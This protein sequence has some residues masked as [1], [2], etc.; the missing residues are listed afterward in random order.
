[1]KRTMKKTLALT[2]CLIMVVSCFTGIITNVQATGVSPIAGDINGDGN[3]NN[4]DLTRLL[5]YIAGEDVEVVTVTIDPNG[6]GN[7]NNKDL[8]RL[9][10]YIAGEAV[11]IF[12]TGCAHEKE[13]V[14]ATKATCTKEGNIAYWYCADCDEYFSDAEGVVKITLEDTVIE[15]I[16]HTEET[17]PG[18]PAT[19]TKTGLTDGVKCSVCKNVLVEQ[20]IIPISES[21]RM[22]AQYSIKSHWRSIMINVT[23]LNRN[24][25]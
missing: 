7:I 15:K 22:I 12:L 20:Q 9:M 4:K 19:M 24:I 16:P 25:L 17:I 14:A 3:V 5:K 21:K 18:Y 1:M 10:K 13:A 6:D 23:I 8:T 11:E 2:L